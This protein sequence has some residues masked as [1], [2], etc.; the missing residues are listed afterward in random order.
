[1]Y[2]SVL[3]STLAGIELEPD[4]IPAKWLLS[5]PPETRSKVLGRSRDRLGYAVLWECGASSYKWHYS[6]DEAYIVLSGEGIM[7]DEQGVEHYFGPGDV[8]F[9]PAGTIATWR[10]SDHFRKVAVLKYS[11]CPS[12]SLGRQV[13]SKLLQMVVKFGALLYTLLSRSPG[14]VK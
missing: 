4:H 5:G 7:T 1:M 6:K 9:F 2:E 12:A 8:A 13:C 10:H 14:S 11:I 3:Q